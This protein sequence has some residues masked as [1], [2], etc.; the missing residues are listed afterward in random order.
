MDTTGH[1]RVVMR[2][3]YVFRRQVE[4]QLGA[5]FFKALFPQR[6][7]TLHQL[8]PEGLPLAFAVVGTVR[9]CLAVGKTVGSC[10]RRIVV[11]HHAQGQQ[12]IA[13]IALLLGQVVEVQL[14]IIR[15]R[16]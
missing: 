13:I 4:R 3:L 15:Y 12:T 2:L 10:P 14:A 1:K 11:A 8:Y 6:K 16:I 5:I 9:A 7:I